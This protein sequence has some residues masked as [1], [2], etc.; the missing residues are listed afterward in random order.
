MDSIN[1]KVDNSGANAQGIYAASESNQ[2]TSEILK[3]ITAAGQTPS[4]SVLDQLMAGLDKFVTGFGFWCTDTGSGGS[5]AIANQNSSFTRI[6]G[7]YVG[8]TLKFRPASNNTSATPALTYRGTSYNLIGEEV[9]LVAG[10]IATTRDCEVRYNGT[11]FVVLQRSI[12]RQISNFYPNGYINGLAV[13]YAGANTIGIGIGECT[14]TLGS[15]PPA[16]DSNRINTRLLA[17][18]TKNLSSWVAGSGGGLPSGVSATAN[19][20]L[21]VFVISGPSLVSAGFDT[22]VSA[23]TLLTVAGSAY[24][25]QRQVGWIR[26]DSGGSIRSFSTSITD[27]SRVTWRGTA[28]ESSSSYTGITSSGRHTITTADAPPGSDAY[29]TGFFYYTSSNNSAIWWI[30]LEGGDSTATTPAN[31]NYTYTSS[32]SQGNVNSFEGRFVDKKIT[33]D[34]SGRY[35]VSQRNTRGGLPGSLVL[36][37][38]NA[39]VTGYE[40]KR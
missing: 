5:Y 7:L 9:A 2:V 33:L 23:S 29:L 1:N 11:T 27:P 20:W 39:F 21:R 14:S 37:Q 36:A 34:S 6:S 40:F 32:S 35:Y 17:S 4:A 16:V 22:N 31:G 30:L 25:H 26:I 19:S 28:F 18:L 8:L 15:N 24:T 12:A 38:Y 13:I 3:V 10:D